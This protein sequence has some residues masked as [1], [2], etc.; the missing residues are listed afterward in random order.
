MER[1][2]TIGVD[3]RVL[4]G[5]S[6]GGIA[7]YLIGLLP[8]L[9]KVDPN[10]KF[11]LF[12]SA[13]RRSLA[14]YDWLGAE[15][16]R[17]FQFNYPNRLL[18]AAS[19][20]LNYP[21]LDY[22][23]QGADVFFSPHF[24]SAPLSPQCQS[25]V[26]YHDLSF[27]RYPEFFSWR[28]NIWHRFEMN[29]KKQ[30][31]EANKIIAVSQSTKDD[32]VNLL[33]IVPEKIEVIY[34]GVLMGKSEI[35]LLENSRARATTER[36]RGS[37]EPSR[38]N[39]GSRVAGISDLSIKQKYN[40]PENFFLYLGALEPRKNI[41]GILKA[42]SFLKSSSQIPK[43]SALVIAGPLG[44]LYTGI[45]KFCKSSPYRESIHLIGP[46]EET[47][48]AR[49]YSLAKV[50]VYPSFFEGFG[51]PPL[52]AM[53]AGVPVITSNI[54][55]L[56][57]VVGGA[58][59]MVDPYNI[60]EIAEAMKSLFLDQNLRDFYIKKGFE[61]VKKFSWRK[62]AEQTLKVITMAVD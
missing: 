34:S 41:L 31:Q 40:L 5:G 49:L 13:Y 28:K 9:F 47:D 38:A 22:L 7:Q 16:V 36:E 62:T 20:F 42:F 35:Q 25:V 24:F 4:A 57:E 11:K 12:F 55:S 17:L 19:R 27:I 23:I 50:F 32:L 44:W 52:E 58:S 33:K 29:P 14:H 6:Y 48:K 15:N 46:V 54:S 45:L 10:I 30:A 3:L 26:T 60:K 2:Y 53:T 8:E 21:K 59:L 43:D 61:Q 51:F 1:D 37:G 18:F 56:P 39:P